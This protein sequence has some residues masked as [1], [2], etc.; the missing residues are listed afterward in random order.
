MAKKM[1]EEL[2]DKLTAAGK[3]LCE[4]CENDEC[5][6]CQ[7]TRLMDDMY[8]EAIEEDIVEN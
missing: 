3:T 2:Y 6:Y 5:Q 4:Y 8:V 1:T 7:V